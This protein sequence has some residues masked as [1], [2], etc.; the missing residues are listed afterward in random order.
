M[1]TKANKN[2]PAIHSVSERSS[3]TR[4]RKI[5]ELSDRLQ[6]PNRFS[7]GQFVR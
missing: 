5:K 6:E 1:S 7:K 2:F 3:T 4:Y